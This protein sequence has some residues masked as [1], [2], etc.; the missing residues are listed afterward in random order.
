MFLWPNASLGAP[1][2]RTAPTLQEAI[3]STLQMHPELQINQGQEELVR[4]AA[5]M[6]RSRLD[7]VLSGVVGHSYAI[8]GNSE[9]LVATSGASTALH[10]TEF[11]VGYSQQLPWGLTL[12]PG[13]TVGR[14]HSLYDGLE[15]TPWNTTDVSVHLRQPL[16]RGRG[17][18]GTVGQLLAADQAVVAAGLTRTHGTQARVYSTIENYWVFIAA[19]QRVSILFASVQFNEKLTS[20]M[21]ELVEADLR[22]RNELVQ[23]KASLSSAR[24]ILEQARAIQFASWQ[25]LGLDMGLRFQKEEI[26]SVPER[27]YPKLSLSSAS[28]LGALESLIKQAM[29]TRPDLQATHQQVKIQRTLR[30]AAKRN[31]APNLA[32]EAHVGYTGTSEGKGAASYFQSLYANVQGLN[33]GASV[34]LDFPAQNRQRRASLAQREAELRMAETTAYDQSRWVRSNVR[35]AYQ[36]VV[37]NLVAYRAVLDSVSRQSEAVEAERLK[38]LEGMSTIIDVVFTQNQL[39]Q[40]R[41]AQVDAQTSVLL[42]IARL[43]YET[44]ALPSEKDEEIDELI[45]H[46]SGGVLVNP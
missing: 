44:G 45:E 34:H 36:Q 14:T 1:K 2:I 8:S 28:H 13:M 3:E 37:S 40:A 32:L 27:F 25:A 43:K 31:L 15:S 22:P 4:A 12:T 7:G 9:A 24:A 39:I 16:L 33:G 41:L 10:A 23:A 20:D 35:Q 30:D 17:R 21:S 46:L 29:K 38:W 26:V 5:L 42:S 6:E 11:N 19:S 18:L